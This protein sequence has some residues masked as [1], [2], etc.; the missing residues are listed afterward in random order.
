M[1]GSIHLHG[2]KVS[3]YSRDITLVDDAEMEK[4]KAIVEDE[5]RYNQ[6]GVVESIEFLTN[7]LGDG[8]RYRS[9]TRVHVEGTGEDPED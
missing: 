3:F 8:M 5:I 2:V 1:S 4:V 6:R 7:Y 9:T